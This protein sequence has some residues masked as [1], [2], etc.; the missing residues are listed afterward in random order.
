MCEIKLQIVR[1]IEA[2]YDGIRQ[3]MRNKNM[4]FLS[5]NSIILS[6]HNKI[7]QVNTSNSDFHTKIENLVVTV[8]DQKA[9]IIAISESNMDSS[10]P[11][12]IKEPAVKFSR[13]EIE[14]NI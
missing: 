3:S 13:F 8:E 2:T 10:D 9:D 6:K 12:K 1:N 11:T 7:L 5:G 4:H 14:D